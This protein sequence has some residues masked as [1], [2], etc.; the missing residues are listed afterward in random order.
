VWADGRFEKTLKPCLRPPFPFSMSS[1]S[2]AVAMGQMQISVAKMQLEA[3]EQQGRDALTLI[4]SST[5]ADVVAA[6]P[7][8][9]ANAAAG[10]GER[11]NVVA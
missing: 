7:A 5:P 6:A 10:V 3:I 11:L 1:V 8:A 2:N 9:P 4:H